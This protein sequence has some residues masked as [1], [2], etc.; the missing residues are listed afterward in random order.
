M[1]GSYL[2][3]YDIIDLRPAVEPC[4]GWSYDCKFLLICN[5]LSIV[6]IVYKSVQDIDRTC[7]SVSGQENECFEHIIVASG[8]SSENKKLILE[9]WSSKRR[10]FLFDLDKSI[11]DAMNIGMGAAKGSAIIYL[12]GGDVFS[13]KESVSVILKNFNLSCIAFSTSQIYGQYIYIRPPCKFRRGEV[14][15][16]AHQGFVSPLEIDKSKRI[17]YNEN[18]YI[19]ADH[20]WILASIRRY[21]VILNNEILAEFFLGGISNKPSLKG[22]KLQLSSGNYCSFLKLIPKMIL[23]VAIGSNR[24]YYVMAKFNKY[25]IKKL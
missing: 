21:G 7:A 2:F 16:C 12:N 23:Y 6:S 24:Y 10:K 14:V 4:S 17:Y 22:L 15:N 3:Y 18:N 9:K 11:Y 20:E 25:E 8:F 5:M 19:S 13:S 1:V